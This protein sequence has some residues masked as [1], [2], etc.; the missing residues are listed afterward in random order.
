MDAHRLARRA[1]QQEGRKSAVR[2]IIMTACARGVVYTVAPSAR[3]SALK[4]TN[5]G[6]K[7]RVIEKF[8][9]AAVQRS[10]SIDVALGLLGEFV[11]D[12]VNPEALAAI[13]RH[14]DRRRPC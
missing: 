14:N 6:D 13:R 10:Q 2:E 8:N 11:G 1:D 4:T 5:L 3:R 7:T 12:A 9:S